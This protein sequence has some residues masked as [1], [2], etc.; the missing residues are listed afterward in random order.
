MLENKYNLE[1]L[2]KASNLKQQYHRERNK[3]DWSEIE[4]ILLSQGI[5]VECDEN[6]RC[7][8]KRYE[9]NNGILKKREQYKSQVIDSK[10]NEV[11]QI[12]GE[13]DIKKEQLKN[14]NRQLNTIKK[15]F[16]KSISISEELKEY[17]SENC[18]VLIPDYCKESFNSIG[19][20]Q[21]LLHISDWHIGY[22]IDDCKGNYYNWEI[23]NQR[24]NQL[25]EE[26]YKY[27]E[28]Y[29]ID[30][31]YVVNTGDII[32]HTY[33]RKNQ[34]Q[35]SEFTQSEQINKA[36]ELIYRLLC[37]LCKYANVE[38]DSIYGNHDRFNGDKTANLDGD[39][40]EVIIREQIKNYKELS[41]NKRLTVIN[42]KH[43]DKE[44]K[45]NINGI[46]CKF[47]HGEDSTKDSKKAI[48]NEISMDNEFYDILFKGHLHNFSVESENNGRYVVYTGCLSGYNDYSV[49]FGCTSV[50][51]QT[52]A[53]FSEN[54][55]EIIKDVQLN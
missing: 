10:L 55:V 14:Q 22:I 52:I 53:V 50:A 27:I 17:F 47:L 8:V 35:F 51:S 15:D 30:K 40:A 44:I 11:K 37:S 23:A 19:K 31:I 38:Y 49:R 13:L 25:I 24:I 1:I 54:K 26:C 7:A 45:K 9:N 32:E 42:R 39:N 20:Y 6:F 3:A 2:E 16:I 34:S 33:M 41:N 12:I 46:K 36:I 5:E 48:K 18:C 28:I 4:E 29:D 21:M 43:T